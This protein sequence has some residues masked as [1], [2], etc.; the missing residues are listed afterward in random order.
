MCGTCQCGIFLMKH[1]RGS[2]L[3]ETLEYCFSY[4][5]F[6]YSDF[7]FWAFSYLPPFYPTSERSAY[8]FVLSEPGC[9]IFLLFFYS[10]FSPAGPPNLPSSSS[11][12]SP[13]SSSSSCSSSLSRCPLTQVYLPYPDLP[14][15]AS[16]MHLLTLQSTIIKGALN[17]SFK[18]CL[19]SCKRKI[20][21]S[22]ENFLTVFIWEEEGG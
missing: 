11:F 17:I 7:S 14:P 20:K 8:L 2:I 1:S 5:K 10:F 19:S 22:E 9:N 12:S 21:M 13:L 3:G 6:Y 16:T 18:G 15:A 4:S